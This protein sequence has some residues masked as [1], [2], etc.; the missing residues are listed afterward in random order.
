MLVIVLS[1]DFA[2]MRNSGFEGTWI[3]QTLVNIAGDIFWINLAW[4]KTSRR[5]VEHLHLYLQQGGAWPGKVRD[6]VLVK[7][8]WHID[9]TFWIGHTRTVHVVEPHALV[10]FVLAFIML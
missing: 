10:W 3:A 9:L 6:L 7:A 5:P 1:L 8:G 4:A 2:A